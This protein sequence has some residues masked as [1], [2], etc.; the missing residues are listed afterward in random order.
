MSVGG[1]R[2]Y[3]PGERE[4]R[5]ICGERP[6]GCMGFVAMQRACVLPRHDEG[7]HVSRDGTTFP[8]K[9]ARR[10]IDRVPERRAASW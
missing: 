1:V 2:R 8:R 3:E 5:P 7:D 9:A 6:T 4:E 10:S